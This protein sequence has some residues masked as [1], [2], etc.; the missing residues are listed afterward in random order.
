[1]IK[2]I[3]KLTIFLLFFFPLCVL[4]K[5]NA[6]V[7]ISGKSSVYI[8]SNISVKVNLNN[9]SGTTNNNGVVSMGGTLSFDSS[10]LQL[11]KIDSSYFQTNGLKMAYASSSLIGIKSSTT[12][13]TITF[14]GL[15]KCSTSVTI[16]G[17]KLTDEVPEVITTNLSPLTI[18]VVPEPSS[19]NYLSNLTVS[20]GS[21][22][23][24]KNTTSYTVNVD[25][26]IN[27]V[28]I[29]AKAE[30]SGASVSGT[31]SKNLSYGNN[32]LQVVVTA[33]NGSKKTYSI[34]VIRKDNRSNNTKLSN[35]TVSGYDINPKFDKDTTSYDL[36]VP[37]DVTKINITATPLDSKSTV[38]IENNDN[39][40]SEKT[41]DVNIIVTAEN[42]STSTYTIHATRGKDP[43]KSLSSNNY[44]SSLS[45]SKGILSPI[46]DKEKTNYV[47]YLPYEIDK[48]DIDAIVDDSKYAKI[49]KNGENDLK[50][51]NN[52]FEFKITA[53]DNS[54]KTY[55]INVI[56]GKNADGLSS[57]SLL[58]EI[59]IKN[60]NLKQSFD[61]N[62]FV[63]NY[64]RNNNFEI[65]AIADDETSNVKIIDNKEVIN[66]IVE[67]SDGTI[68]I[69]S[70]IPNN[71]IIYII[72]P[73]ALFLI[74][75]GYILINKISKKK[76]S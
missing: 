53:E 49:E 72:I 60:G 8:G 16:S 45:V 58:K 2:K 28:T 76:K 42:N 37:F 18:S 4:A 10:C 69:Y 68:S 35:L 41:V 65:N 33:P 24:N 13:A 25:S 63:Y 75:T 51:G 36:T 21:I 29:G 40:I 61:K 23:F 6:S 38:K 31:G 32:N 20:S 62:K 9:I 54:I 57:N 27:K 64:S 39:L 15:K 22:S 73:S 66:I 44:L 59:T 43:N 67:A 70:L 1:M 14:K 50:V 19:N 47:V 55:T 52:L 7:Q 17:L 26:T 3:I 34:N 74:A 48:I 71:N 56:R 11:V 12:M 46:F 30:D 5:G